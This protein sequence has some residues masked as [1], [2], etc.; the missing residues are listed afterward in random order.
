MGNRISTFENNFMKF[1]HEIAKGA[2]WHAACD[3]TRS[4]R[5]MFNRV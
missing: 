5:R 3:H 1:M 4:Q 2:V